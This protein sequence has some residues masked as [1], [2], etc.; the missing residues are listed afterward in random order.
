M[1]SEIQASFASQKNLYALI[2]GY[3]SNIGQIWN[4]AAFAVYASVNYASF[5]IALV[6]QG[7][8]SGFY[9]GTFP[10]AIVAGT[11]SVVVKQ[12]IGG[13]AA[14]TDPTVA[15]GNIDWNGANPTP[16]SDLATSGQLGQIGPVKIA[17]GTMVKN[18]PVYLKSAS[19]HS[20]PFTS[21]VI[22]GQIS[23]DGGNFGALQSGAFT[24]VGLGFYSTTLTS[25]D[26]LANTVSLLFTGNGISGGPC[27]PLPMSLVLQRVSGQ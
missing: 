14:E 16:L 12:Q 6:E 24:E 26:L 4:G 23:R 7:T 15:A 10:S 21:G 13:S 20:T 22:S 25:G 9:T 3:S 5:P 19:D 8:A 2:R 17:R 1:A 18:W 27:D 11:Y